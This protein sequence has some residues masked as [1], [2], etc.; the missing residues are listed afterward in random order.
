[1]ISDN[2]GFEEPL[3]ET[4]PGV[5]ATNQIK[6]KVGNTYKLRIIVEEEVYE[7]TTEIKRV[8]RID[9][10]SFVYEKEDEF[11]DLEAGYEVK[12]FGPELPGVGDY[13]RFKVYKNNLA[14]NDPSD[15]VS[16]SDE[17]VD[18][19]YIGDVQF[20]GWR[21]QAGDS[22]KVE[23]MGITEEA[24]QFFLELYIQINNAESG[25]FANPVANIHSNVSNEQLFQLSRAK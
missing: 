3:V 15:L 18:G 21:F 17:L 2:T 12:Y 13:F 9:S 5:Y 10:L 7:A 25:I 8:P 16:Y 6:G 19:K 23:T 1:V 4:A 20:E 22:V 14:F 11:Q 24:Y